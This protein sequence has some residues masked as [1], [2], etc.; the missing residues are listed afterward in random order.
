[1]ETNT[2]FKLWY[3]ALQLKIDNLE[4]YI[5]RELKKYRVLPVQPYN[6]LHE[7]CTEIEKKFNRYYEENDSRIN[8][9]LSDVKKDNENFKAHYKETLNNITFEYAELFSKLNKQNIKLDKINDFI[10]TRTEEL[11]Q[12][13][14]LVKIEGELKKYRRGAENYRRKGE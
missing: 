7:K 1:M 10:I 9:L 3:S 11:N 4:E 2:N 8:N 13:L 14:T 6:D 12:F 5:K